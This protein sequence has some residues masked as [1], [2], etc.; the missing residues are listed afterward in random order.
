MIVDNI[1][2]VTFLVILLFL[3]PILINIYKNRLLNNFTIIDLIKTF[4]KSL[5]IQGIIALCMFVFG[6][7]SFNFGFL[8]DIIIGTA[9]TYIIVGIFMYLPILFILNLIRVLVE[10]IN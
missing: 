2:I 3:I 4:N 7:L 8:E 6:F 10:K 1:E 9:Y 5:R